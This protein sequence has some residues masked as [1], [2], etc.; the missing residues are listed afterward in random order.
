MR[1]MIATK[2]ASRAIMI[3][4]LVGRQNSPLDCLFLTVE[5]FVRCSTVRKVQSVF[6]H[7]N[8]IDISIVQVQIS[9]LILPETNSGIKNKTDRE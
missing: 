2:V 3:I 8:F 5:F 1:K 9:N 4:F 7:T 6:S